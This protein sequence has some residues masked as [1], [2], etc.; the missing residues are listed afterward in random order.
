M[1][2]Q[3]YMDDKKRK[4]FRQNC[5]N[6]EVSA[7]SLINQFIDYFN[8]LPHPTTSHVSKLLD[9]DLRREI[10]KNQKKEVQNELRI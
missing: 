9:S 4:I 7:A 5:L 10:K 2:L 3:V 1:S 6:A 8:A